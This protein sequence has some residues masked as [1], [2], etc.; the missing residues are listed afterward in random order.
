MPPLRMEADRPVYDYNG[1]ARSLRIDAAEL[2]RGFETAAGAAPPL[3][4]TEAH[5]FLFAPA[6]VFV[7]RCD[8]ECMRRIVAA[9]EAALC[10]P[11]VREEVL[12]RAP[13]IAQAAPPAKSVLFGYDFHLGGDGPK[14]IEIN[15]NA[16]GALLN[17]ALARAARAPD[18][19]G[20]LV[21]APPRLDGVEA[22]LVDMFRREWRHAQGGAPLRRI[23]I[24]DDTPAEQ[25]LY[26]EFVLFQ[27]L[28]AGAGIEAVI[29]AP[30]ELRFGP[31]LAHA[32][33]P[34]DLVYNRLTDFYLEASA[35]AAV[36]EAYVS[37]EAVVT[38]H[39]HAHAL[40]ANKRNLVLLGDPDFLRRAGVAEQA[41][42]TLAAGVPPATRVAD[43]NADALWR[44]RKRWFFK[45]TAGY[46]SKAAY[47]GDKLTRGT[48]AEIRRGDYIAQQTVPPSERVLEIDGAPVSFKI[49][50]RNFAY[51]GEVQFVAARLYRG[52]TTN[53]RTAGG[54]FAPVLTEATGSPG[55]V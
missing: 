4:F 47:R 38:P 19:Q 21:T 8:L 53:L 33:R 35:H 11:A 20:R 40:Y 14:L 1:D 49:D 16:G 43:T 55:T 7:S 27:R 45:P 32:G 2:Q 44:E 24:V 48:F 23:A 54:G 34:I 39:P 18:E 31:P 52:Q 9:A 26:P 6:A 22:A 5:R 51:D 37:G 50:I 42:A 15:T 13:L 17:V 28:F 36:R 10:T 30:E 46:G 29:A 41:V 3:A 25:F 12:G